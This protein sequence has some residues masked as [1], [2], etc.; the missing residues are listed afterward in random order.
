MSSIDII[1]NSLICPVCKNIFSSPVFLPCY[2]TICEKHTKE[3]NGSSKA[4]KCFFCH[5]A[6]EMPKEGYKRNDMVTNLID[7][8]VY[9]N[10]NEINIKNE[11]KKT[12]AELNELL[13][14]F[15]KKIPKLESCTT[16]YFKN[17]RDK[18]GLQ[19]KELISKIDEYVDGVLDQAKEHENKLKLKLSTFN[20][21]NSNL[22]NIASNLNAKIESQFK[23]KSIEIKSLEAIKETV[24]NYV[25]DVKDSFGQLED[26]EA[27][28]KK[29][30]F[31]PGSLSLIKVSLINFFS[32]VFKY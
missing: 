6:H 5:V 28:I 14:E 4:Y 26:F 17:L 11:L 7:S 3:L 32:Y 21:T 2:N 15:E 10:P 18:I 9:L 30:K 29:Y 13:Q 12:N 16:E 31:K 8:G 20:S 19:K 25:N 27:D 24:L 1:K 23:S 22:K